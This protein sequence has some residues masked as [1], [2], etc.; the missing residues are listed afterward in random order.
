MTLAWV[1]LADNPCWE[2]LLNR[3]V[4]SSSFSYNTL[5]MG[6]SGDVTAAAH[7][8]LHSGLVRAEHVIKWDSPLQNAVVSLLHAV[9]TPELVANATEEPSLRSGETEAS[10][11]HAPSDIDGGRASR[12]D[13]LSALHA[14]RHTRGWPPT[15]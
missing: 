13:E 7:S 8:N 11:S 12:G 2:D 14:R 1:R 6:G 3:S 15:S 4:L 9:L 10:G 5:T